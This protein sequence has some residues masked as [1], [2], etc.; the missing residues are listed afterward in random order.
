MST[1]PPSASSRPSERPSRRRWTSRDLALVAAF[2][3]LIAALGLPGPLY[4]PGN[5]VPVT[6]QTLGVMLAGSLLG[7]RRG[8]A[9]VGVLLVLVAAGLPLLAGGRGGLAVFAGPS[10]GYLLCWPLAAA[11]IGVLA[12]RFLPRYPLGWGILVNVLGG[13]VLV[14]AVGVPVSAAVLGGQLWPAVVQ[15]AAYL[16]GDLLKSVVAAVVTAGVLRAQP[17]LLR[18]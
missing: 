14:Y 8:A 15:S 2:A 13:I 6:A 4:L 10:V 5:A 9:A 3:G 18:P 7:W 16:P 17:S 12:R 11:V 1:A